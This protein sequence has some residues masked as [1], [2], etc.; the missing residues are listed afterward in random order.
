[1]KRKTL[2]TFMIAA[3]SMLPALKATSAT[4]TKVQHAEWSRNAVIYEVNIRQYTP[5]GT[6]NAFSRQLPRLKNLGVDI[7]WIMP[8]NPIS[9][10]GRK[11]ELGSYYA[12]QDYKKTNP[13]F[14]TIADFKSLV[15][16]AHKLG[17][18][19]ILDWVANHTG[20]DNVWM[21]AHPDFYA[22]DSLGP[23]NTSLRLD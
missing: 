23:S 19:V 14:G 13:E 6:F 15:A 11:G 4:P 3:L 1:M 18:K 9:V 20:L 8:I 21:K 10:E 16:K 5:E 17:M 22:K 12:V 2:F 7:L